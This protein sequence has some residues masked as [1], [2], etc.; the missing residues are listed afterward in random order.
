MKITDVEPLDRFRLRVRFDDGTSGVADLGHLA[1]RGV[2][3]SWNEPGVF[4]Q[5]SITPVGALEWPGE[6]D[7]C[8]DAVYLQVTGKRPEEVF[9]MLRRQFDHA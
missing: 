9:P 8:P 1:G 4:E 3:Q 5:V 7:L 2:F 6:I